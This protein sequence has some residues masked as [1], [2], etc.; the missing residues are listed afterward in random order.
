MTAAAT[1]NGCSNGSN[2]CSDGCSDG[3]R[4]GCSNCCSDGCSDGCLEGAE[5]KNKT[6]RL[7]GKIT[8]QLSSSEISPSCHPML[9]SLPPVLC[10]TPLL[11]SP[12]KQIRLHAVL[13]CMELFY[14]YAPSPPWDDAETL[15]IFDQTIRQLGNLAHCTVSK[16]FDSFFRILEML[17]EV[18]IGVVLDRERVSDPDQGDAAG[19]YQDALGGDASRSSAGGGDSCRERHCRLS[20]GVRDCHS[21]GVFDEL[22]LAVGQGPVVY[23]TNPEYAKAVARKK[24]DGAEKE[25]PPKEI[26]QTSCAYLVAA[27]VIRK[28]E[29]NVSSP[30][31]AL[32][33]GLLGGDESIVQKTSIACANSEEW[34]VKKKGTIAVT[35][36]SND[37]NVYSITYE[38]HRI[39]PNILTTVIGTV[40]SNLLSAD[41]GARGR[42]TQLLGRLFGARTS[43]VARRFGPCFREW[44]RR[45]I[46]SEPKIR[47]TMVKCLTNFLSNKHAE[48]SLCEDVNDALTN[49]ILNEP[50]LDIRLL[51]IHQVCDLAHNATYGDDET[52]SRQSNP[53]ISVIAAELLQ[54]VGNR[55]GSKNKTEHRDA[56]TGLV[57]IYHRHFVKRKLNDIQEGGDNINIGEILEVLRTEC[58]SSS[59]DK[60]K[61]NTAEDKFGWIPQKVF[62]CVSF[63]DATDPDMR[64]RV[65]QLVDDVLLGSAKSPSLSP[66]SRAVGLAIILHSLKDKEN[67]KKWMTTLFTQ[68]A[69]LQRALASYLDAR[70]RAKNCESGSAEAF[71]ADAEAMEKLEVVASLTAPIGSGSPLNSDAAF[72]VLKKLHTA[73]DKHIFR[74]LSTI[75]TPIH[76]PSAR[77]R[78]FDELPKRTNSLGNETSSWVKSLARRCA[79]GSFFNTESIE[80]C[81]ILSQECFEAGDCEAS[82]MFLECVK[83]ATSVFPA[84]GA[85]GE[86]FKNLAEFFDSCQTTSVSVSTKKDMDKFG[87]VTSISDI[88]AKAASSRPTVEGK[89]KSDE[90]TATLRSQLLCLCTRDGTP[91]QAKNSVHAILSLINPHTKTMDVASCIRK[92]K[93]EFLPL[94]KALVNPSRLS[95]PDDDS[96]LKHQSRIVSVLSAIAAI[97]ECAPYAFNAPGEVGKSGWGK[98]ALDFA[99]NTVLLGKWQSINSSLDADGNT[100]SENEGGSPEKS[101][102][103]SPVF[104]EA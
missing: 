33:N 102:R 63:P 83:I 99:L 14:V 97:S 59:A 19:I 90:S 84:L 71:T 8:S 12:D 82:S 76:S 18:K 36:P 91:D 93:E 42:A 24:R 22:L 15:D 60:R 46:D 2:G 23:V 58:L 28:T 17:S 47:E 75:A 68:R 27:K 52:V 55:V 43:D 6:I 37:V 78:A 103:S 101:G 64:N 62:E 25:L 92:E 89:S 38:L 4:D 65:F 85:T 7:L 32:L 74:I 39:A 44:L 50:V 80:H 49:I 100:E 77:A 48:T 96:N 104:T 95:I 26:Q 20:R 67:A 31:A 69:N 53:P 51:A 1:G 16:E 66:T 54:A 45:S 98:R 73:K 10:L 29:D 70:L 88:L 35:A 13:A 57:Q 34:G 87:L 61:K 40:A 5:S 81:I 94:L 9:A 30:V 56:I 11:R 72:A 3:C 86:C 79:M 21:I 41:V